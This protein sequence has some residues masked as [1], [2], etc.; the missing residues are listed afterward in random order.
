MPEPQSTKLKINIFS[1]EWDIDLSQPCPDDL[2][3][4]NFRWQKYISVSV[5]REIARR[6]WWTIKHINTNKTEVNGSIVYESRIIITI[7]W[8]DCF[9][10][11]FDS[12]PISS[13]WKTM[14][15]NVARMQALA[16]KNALKWKYAF[17]ETDLLTAEQIG[18][19]WIWEWVVPVTKNTTGEDNKF[20]E[21]EDAIKNAQAAA[22][23]SQV[24]A[25]ITKEAQLWTITS[26]Q[27]ADL[28][29][30]YNERY[31]QLW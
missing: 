13:I 14:F 16:V 3:E 10:E 1:K 25:M 20:K 9:W 30:L 21:L 22:G 28:I 26:Q 12:H 29:K 17:F 2:M 4:T 24:S 7:D 18:E 11:A 8:V 31:A 6:K 19:K 23:L 15:P 27:K 5:I